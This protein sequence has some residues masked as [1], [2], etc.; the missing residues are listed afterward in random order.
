MKYIYGMCHRG[1]SIGCQPMDG[2]LERKD[3]KTTK[4]WDLLIY[5]RELTK[6]EMRDYE[7]DYLGK[8]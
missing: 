3:D 8:K 7:L 5:T 4:Y 6:K 1:F 2:L